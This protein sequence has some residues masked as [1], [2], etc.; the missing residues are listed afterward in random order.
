M[1][2]NSRTLVLREITADTPSPA[3]QQDA[4]AHQSRNILIS[5]L[6]PSLTN[7]GGGG[8]GVDVAVIC[9]SLLRTRDE[10]IGLR[11]AKPCVSAEYEQARSSTGRVLLPLLPSPPL[12]PESDLDCL[13]GSWA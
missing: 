6:M 12:G 2:K 5:N 1:E 9:A 8:G 3:Q 7:E 4:S 10:L 11:L 13:G